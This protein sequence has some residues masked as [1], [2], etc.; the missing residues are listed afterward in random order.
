M[1]TGF[2]YV[3]FALSFLINMVLSIHLL[4]REPVCG[5]VHLD[6]IDRTKDVI[7][8]E[9]TAL[10][11]AKEKLIHPMADSFVYEYHV[12]FNEPSYEWIV[13][14]EARAKDGGFVLDGGDYLWLRRDYGTLSNYRR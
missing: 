9:E 4:K 13:F 8:D 14:I 10:R 1:K 11:L 2:L 12:F 7:P 5:H 3:C 6:E